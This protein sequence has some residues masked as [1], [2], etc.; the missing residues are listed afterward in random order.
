MQT[1]GT[2]ELRPNW[3]ICCADRFSQIGGVTQV[4]LAAC[5]DVIFL[6]QGTEAEGH[7]ATVMA[8]VRWRASLDRLG[9]D[10]GA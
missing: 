3:S 7:P 6:L 4:Q 1:V 9:P 10:A 2:I 8:R 5:P